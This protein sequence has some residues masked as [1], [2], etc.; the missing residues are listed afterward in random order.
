MHMF[1]QLDLLETL[2]NVVCLQCINVLL[3]FVR[4][5]FLVTTDSLQQGEKGG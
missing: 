5:H 1:L 3:P 4:H 2:G